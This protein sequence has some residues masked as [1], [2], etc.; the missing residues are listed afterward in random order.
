MLRVPGNRNFQQRYLQNRCSPEEGIFVD[1]CSDPGHQGDER[2]VA[3]Q[4][5][6]LCTSLVG[7]IT[8]GLLTGLKTVDGDFRPMRNLAVWIGIILASSC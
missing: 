7:G 8:L 5:A 4:V 6:T 3:L 2:L 1:F